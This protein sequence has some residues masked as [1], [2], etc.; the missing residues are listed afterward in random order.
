MLGNL[1]TIHQMAKH[2]GLSRGILPRKE[3][4]GML[5]TAHCHP[6]NGYR[7]LPEYVRYVNQ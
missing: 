4:R 1:F 7:Y 2:T 3:K 5:T 6:E